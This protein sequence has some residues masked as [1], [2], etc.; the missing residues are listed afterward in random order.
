MNCKFCNAEL[1][2]NSSIC[3]D[4]GRDNAESVT[5]EMIEEVNTEVSAETP[6][7]KR[8][9]WVTI[10]AVI[11]GVVLLAVLVGAVIYGTKSL[12]AKTVSYSV[13]DAKA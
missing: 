1:E 3:P 13:S 12:G 2:K 5:T 7:K 8:S 6:R 11:G 10:L 4:C 9:L